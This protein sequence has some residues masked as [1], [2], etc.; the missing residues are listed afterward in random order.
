MEADHILKNKKILIVDDTP[1]N[2]TVLRKLLT[3]KGYNVRPA[4]NGKIALKSIK[5]DRPDLI[6]LDIMCLSGWPV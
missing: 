5:E 3:D 4:I 2:L 1:E 6:L